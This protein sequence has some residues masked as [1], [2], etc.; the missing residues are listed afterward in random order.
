MHSVATRHLPQ[1]ND[2]RVHLL[3][4]QKDGSEKVLNQDCGEVEREQ[5]QGAD[6][7]R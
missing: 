4:S 5:I 7:C 1:N 6:F 3:R 2:P